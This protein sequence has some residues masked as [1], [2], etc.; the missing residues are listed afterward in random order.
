[1]KHWFIGLILV[2]SCA[3]SVTF[4]N[5]VDL[6]TA[7]AAADSR[8]P[9]VDARLAFQDAER[10][11]VRT[12][13]DPLALRLDLVQAQHAVRQGE[14]T[15]AQARFEAY[16]AIGRAYTQ[17]LE[18]DVQLALAER[19]RDLAA[20][21]LEIARIRLERGSATRLDVQDAETDLARATSNVASAR[22][23]REL[24]LTQLA[25]LTERKD[26]RPTT[27]DTRFLAIEIPAAASV[28]AGLAD[29]PS[30]LQARQGLELAQ[31]AHELLDPSYAAPVQIEQAELQIARAEEAAA[32]ARRGLSL[33]SDQ[34][35]NAVNSAYD[36]MLVE[37]DAVAAARDREATEVQRYEAGLIAEVQLD[38]ARL[39]TAQ[40]ELA[41]LQAAHGY[42][43]ALLD[44]QAATVTPIEGL[45][46]F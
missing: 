8:P 14:R 38:Q 9:V 16:A 41:A 19:A 46:G 11:L 23:G 35:L 44:L 32:E 29:H 20:R 42:L 10:N 17:A 27:V 22:E 4:A 33:Q 6:A 45:H 2:A 18:A 15:L 21:S 39:A 25:S 12:E 28:T 40:A 13:A 31:V 43:L 34:R 1:M 26:P 3:T 30:L 24:A 5:E 36:R 37:R 7:L